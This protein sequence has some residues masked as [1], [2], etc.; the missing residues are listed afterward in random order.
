M[1]FWTG[2]WYRLKIREQNPSRGQGTTGNTESTR[3]PERFRVISPA[4]WKD[5]FTRRI[6]E[7]IILWRNTITNIERVSV[8][9]EK[10]AFPS[11]LKRNIIPNFHFHTNESSS[12]RLNDTWISNVALTFRD[13]RILRCARFS[14][15]VRLLRT[16]SCY[17]NFDANKIIEVDRHLSI[18]INI[19]FARTGFKCAISDRK[20]EFRK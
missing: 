6:R 2:K 8:K 12:N 7:S 3:V 4:R 13:V 18:S 19:F 5:Q 11:L 10:S 20:E 1:T 14:R 9:Y 15:W 17:I 16:K